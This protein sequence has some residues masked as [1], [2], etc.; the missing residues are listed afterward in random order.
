MNSGEI[1]LVII[2]VA[3]M[4][5]LG[6]LGAVCFKKTSINGGE[7]KVKEL[8][9]NKWLYLGGILYV[10][11]AVFN[12]IVLKFL[13]YSVVMSF[14]SITYIWTII[15]SNRFFHEKINKFKV[16]AICCIVIGVVLLIL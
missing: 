3:L 1:I 11:G 16:L 10:A 2:S 12:I 9:K 8:L 7:F 14:S 13:P 15:F 5:C 4:T 6:S